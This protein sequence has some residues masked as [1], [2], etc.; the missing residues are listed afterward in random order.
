MPTYT[1]LTTLEGKDAANDLGVA[2]ENLDSP[3]YGIGV[4]EIEDGSGL[5]E[6]GAYFIDAPNEI[7]LLILST[8]YSAKP[9]VVSEVPDKDWV[10]EVRRELAPVEAG[11]FFV[12]G[13]HD[14]DKVPANCKPLLIEA[15]MAFGTGHH[16]TT[17]GCLTALDNLFKSGFIGTNVVD[18]GCGTAV[19]AMGAA[20]CW[21]GKVLASDIDEIATETSKANAHANGLGDRIKIITCAGFDHP[22][23]NASAPYDLILANILKGPLVALAPD[24]SKNSIL[25]GYIILS[26]LLNTQA[27]AVIDAYSDESFELVDHIK[28]TEWSILTL[29]KI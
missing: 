19:L 11:D 9:F 1:S 24:M 10:A 13:S 8:A 20:L 5:Y 7:E 28:I 17:K 21:P 14:S 26:G 27:D 25:G 22:D 16:G 18:I 23:L 4:F 6:V 2:L 3:P 29:R 12:Y 15:A